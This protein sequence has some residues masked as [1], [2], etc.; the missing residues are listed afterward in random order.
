M[1]GFKVEVAHRLGQAEAV[2]RLQGFSDKIKESYR[3]EITDI[4]ESWSEGGCL[5]FSFKAMGFKISGNVQ[6]HEESVSL[7]GTLPMA[8]VMFRG[9]IEKEIKSKLCEALGTSG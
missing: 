7:N 2:E 8:A 3:T 6:V 4:Q 5:D 1:P 9:A